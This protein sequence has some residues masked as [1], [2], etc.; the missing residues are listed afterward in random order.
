MVTYVL[1]DSPETLV[2][3]VKLFMVTLHVWQS[4]VADIEHPDV[5]LVDLDPVGSCTLA[6][7]ARAALY[8]RDA[9]LELGVGRPL[10]K[11]S[12]ARGLHVITYV[13]PQLDYKAMRA[14]SR[15]VAVELAR[16]HPREL[17]AERD[18]R[19]R[20]D[21]SIYIDW[22][23][24]GRGMTIVPPF[25]PRACDGAPVSMPL[26][27]SEIERCTLSRSKRSPLEYFKR[28]N[29]GNAVDLLKKGG[30]PWAIERAHR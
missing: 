23:Q 26:R 14:F 21:G 5:F 18:P 3:L 13:E 16:R 28:Y 7:L 20:P 9:L 11:S 29:I 17:T 22:G 19:E 25:T 15:D 10:V 6:R 4:T 8:V 2:Y 12:G 30:D 1:V 24:V 27:W